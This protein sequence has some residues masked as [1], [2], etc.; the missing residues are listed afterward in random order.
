MVENLKSSKNNEEWDELT[1]NFIDEIDNTVLKNATV[2]LR[3]ILSDPILN[4]SKPNAST[5]YENTKKAVNDYFNGVLKIFDSESKALNQ[6]LENSSVLYTKFVS[7]IAEKAEQL[8]IPYIKPY[9]VEIKDS[10]REVILLTEFNSSVEFL[11]GKLISSSKYV[12]DISG[13]YKD[14]TLG[15]WIFS[16]DRA[17]NIIIKPPE[18]IVLDI[19]NSKDVILSDLDNFLNQINITK[20]LNNSN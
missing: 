1:N 13:T 11:I 9:L 19:E 16:S 8:K 6:E 12:A 18:S 15:S 10:Y 3:S 2:K 7:I 5:T 4:S 20:T 14:H 17:Y